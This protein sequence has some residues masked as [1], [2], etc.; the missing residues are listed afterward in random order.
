VLAELDDVDVGRVPELGPALEQGL[1]TLEQGAARIRGELRVG[2]ASLAAD[3]A[4]GAAL[5]EPVA[6]GHVAVAEGEAVQHRQAVEPV[7]KRLFPGLE[8]RRA[9]AQQR[10]AQPGG[11]LAVDR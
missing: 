11:E 3:G 2:D 9:G 1:D 10:A 8:L 4:L 7:A 5:Q 6:V